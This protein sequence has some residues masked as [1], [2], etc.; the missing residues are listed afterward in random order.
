MDFF[1]PL[2]PE[3]I[4]TGRSKSIGEIESDRNVPKLIALNRVVGIQKIIAQLKSQI[5]AERKK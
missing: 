5:S 1:K 2:D 4:K 3:E